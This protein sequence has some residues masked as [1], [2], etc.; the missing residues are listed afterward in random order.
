MGI[1]WAKI[2]TAAGSAIKAASEN[3]SI[4]KMVLGTYTDGTPRSITDAYQ[5]EI[6]SPEDRLL[7]EKR[8]KKIRKKK[9]KK[10]KK[11]DKRK[12]SLK[13]NIKSKGLY[14]DDM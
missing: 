10:K 4:K 13:K 7:I 1:E 9:G 8:M 14:H 11:L 2:A 6:L 12:E 3:D 5:G